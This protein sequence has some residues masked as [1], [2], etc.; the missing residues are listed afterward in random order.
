MRR[1]RRIPP[2]PASFLPASS[3]LPDSH[4]PTQ[5]S[6]RISSLSSRLCKGGG[7]WGMIKG[8]GKGGLV[9]CVYIQKCL[10]TKI[11]LVTVDMV[12]L[13]IVPQWSRNNEWYPTFFK[14][15]SSLIQGVF[16]QLVDIKSKLFKTGKAKKQY[17]MIQGV[18]NISWGHF[19]ST[20][21]RS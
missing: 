11:W 16:Q 20:W 1:R 19:C 21:C 14:K 13:E 4:C 6:T 3:L 7:R 15:T 8:S 12:I 2:H 9:G 5:I 17:S 18:C 10:L